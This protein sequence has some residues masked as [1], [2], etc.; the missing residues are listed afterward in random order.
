MQTN[1]PDVEMR[2]VVR[3]KR[4][5]ICSGSERRGESGREEEVILGRGGRESGGCGRMTGAAINDKEVGRGWQVVGIGQGAEL[6]AL[7][8]GGCVALTAAVQVS[9]H[10]SNCVV[11]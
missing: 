5:V 11:T 1:Q 6:V 9:R 3:L 10:H 2:K 7:R 4:A 8:G